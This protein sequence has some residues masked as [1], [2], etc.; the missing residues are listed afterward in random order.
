MLCL[1]DE[2][3]RLSSLAAFV[4]DKGIA[5]VAAAV[6]LL[7]AAVVVEEA[8]AVAAAVDVVAAVAVADALFSSNGELSLDAA[9]VELLA[10]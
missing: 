6:A 9:V 5:V 3:G 7:F 10:L 4:G 1:C 8:I 2:R